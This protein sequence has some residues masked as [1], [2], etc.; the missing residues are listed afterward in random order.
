MSLS[1]AWFHSLLFLSILCKLLVQLASLSQLYVSDSVSVSASV[2][3]EISESNSDEN[4]L[5]M[6]SNCPVELLLAV[7]FFQYVAFKFPIGSYGQQFGK[8]IKETEHD[9]RRF[10]TR[11]NRG[12]PSPTAK[13]RSWLPVPNKKTNSNIV[14]PCNISEKSVNDKD[15]ATE[16]DACQSWIHLKCNKL[17]HIDYKYFQG[18]SDPWFCLYF[19]SSIFPLGF[20]T[21]KDF[22]S[23]LYS[24]NEFENFSNKKS[25]TYLAALPNLALLSNQFNNSSWAKCWARKCFKF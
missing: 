2:S 20:L 13:P 16:C 14:F 4:S 11:C 19:C 3:I 1:N 7:T 22:L 23:F 21:N 25:S 17:N 9:L 8:P 15:P 10:Q 24:R 12:F 6:F 18:S 5:R